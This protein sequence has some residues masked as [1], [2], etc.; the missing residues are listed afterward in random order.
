[1][2]MMA[3][4]RPRRWAR[5]LTG[6]ASVSVAAVRVSPGPASAGPDDPLKDVPVVPAPIVENENGGA[7]P[8]D[9]D[10]VTKVRLAGL[11]E[12]P[13]GNM[14]VEKGASKRVREIGQ[15]IS[16]QHSKL[17]ELA[18]DTAS[19]LRMP[20]PD[21]PNAEQKVWLGEMR[22]ST[23]AEFDQIF[24][25]RLRAAHGKIFPVIGTIR[26]GT[27]NDSVRLLAQQ[28]NQ[29]VLT[30]LTLLESTGLV[31]WSALPKPPDPGPAVNAQNAVSAAGPGV[32]AS[33]SGAAA[34]PTSPVVWLILVI[35]LVAGVFS[36]IRLFKP[37]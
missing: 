30:H 31:D 5:W 21:E 37:R 11:W 34:A 15:M 20:L 27:G 25:D 26:S 1:M 12:M 10:F 33:A 29:Y 23:G 9:R 4:S 32:L 22:R 18:R 35:A 2:E 3:E 17:D 7:P 36:A 19:K 6:A 8:A 28:T 16:E 24:V 14:A 13:A